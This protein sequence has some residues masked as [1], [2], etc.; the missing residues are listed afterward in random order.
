MSN[1]AFAKESERERKGEQ[2]CKRG[3]KTIVAAYQ[4]TANR[5]ISQHVQSEQAQS[6]DMIMAE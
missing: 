5:V 1:E 4:V 6:D 2:Q 3:R